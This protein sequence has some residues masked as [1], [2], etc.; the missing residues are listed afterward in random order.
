MNKK[1]IIWLVILVVLII[2]FFLS[3]QREFVERRMDLFN[4]NS[5]DITRIEFIQP[6][7]TLIIVRTDAGWMIEHPIAFPVR[8]TQ[9]TRFFT[10]FIGLSASRTPISESVD[11][12]ERFQVDEASGIQVAIFGRNNRLLSR[13]FFGRGQNPNVAYI[14]A[15][16]DN[17]IYQISNVF[18]AVNPTM[19]VW[20][21]DRIV[22]FAENEINSIS[23]ARGGS[24]YSLT[25]EFGMWNIVY[26]GEEHNIS[27][28]NSDFRR[29]MNALTGLR[30]SVFFDGEYENFAARLANPNLAFLI[31]LENG[32]EVML[33]IVQN[34]ENTF[35]LQ[36]NGETDTLFRLMLGQFNQ[37]DV[38]GDRF[39][40]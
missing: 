39:I 38:E 21:E 3:R 35:A 13:M 40:E 26:N 4:F 14:R 6:A 33:S 34:D 2:V 32:D 8:E 27:Q 15:A 11:R 20:R 17:K 24:S 10:D 31:T 29:F 22:T 19:S 28:G 25:Q 12:Q 18:S 5:D 23:V 30:T 9:L 1:N 16:N 7:D 37:L 36:R